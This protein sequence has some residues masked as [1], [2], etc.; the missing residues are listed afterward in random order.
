MS[1]RDLFITVQQ[2]AVEVLPSA[3]HSSSFVLRPGLRRLRRGKPRLYQSSF[4]PP[5]ILHRDKDRRADCEIYQQAP[6]FLEKRVP[7]YRGQMWHEQEID[8]VACEHSHE[9]I[10]KILHRRFSHRGLTSASA[11]AGISPANIA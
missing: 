5:G 8:R 6:I 11:P 4:M 9:R 1:L 2:I 3:G 7:R 10:E